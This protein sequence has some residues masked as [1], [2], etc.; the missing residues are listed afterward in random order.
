MDTIAMGIAKMILE[1][2]RLVVRAILGLGTVVEVEE[3]TILTPKSRHPIALAPATNI[4]DDKK[5]DT[6]AEVV[7]RTNGNEMRVRK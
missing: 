2:H 6:G 1:A 4:D 7:L 5:V 3:V